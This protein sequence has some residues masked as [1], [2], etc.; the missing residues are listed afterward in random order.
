MI[1]IA[2]GRTNSKSVHANNGQRFSR[3]LRQ[4]LVNDDEFTLDGKT[5]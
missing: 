5:K 3:R 4:R 1:A 2:L